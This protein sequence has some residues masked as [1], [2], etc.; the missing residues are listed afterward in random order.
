MLS[1]SV[2]TFAVCWAWINFTWFASA[3]DTD[4]WVFRLMTMVE[5]VGVLVLA[6]GLPAFYASIEHGHHVD[7]AVLVAGYAYAHATTRWFPPRIQA[8]IHVLLLAMALALLPII[9]P[10]AWRPQGGENPAGHILLLLA[11]TV[12]LPYF[13]LATTGPLLQA[14]YSHTHGG[15]APYR[16]YALSN[17]AS[18]LAL[19]TYPVWFEA[20]LPRRTQALLWG[21]GLL[22]YAIGAASCAWRFMRT[23]PD[24]ADPNPFS[25][26]A[27]AGVALDQGPQEN[28]CR[29]AVD[30]MFR[31]VAE[32]FDVPGQQ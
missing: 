22:L 14:W 11:A 24:P 13:L 7:N 2:A 25:A 29:P 27:G 4:D 18:L 8:L 16:L 17:A 23:R 26:P 28:Y 9:P 19:I 6:L 31:S 5:M 15:A 10:D 32:V 21:W 12:G 20:H 1:F 3:Y 30:P